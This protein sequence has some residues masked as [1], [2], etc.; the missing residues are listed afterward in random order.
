MSEKVVSTVDEY[1]AAILPFQQKVFA[2]IHRFGSLRPAILFRGEK[3]GV[4]LVA[5]IGKIVEEQNIEHPLSFER[6]RL[7]ITQSILGAT[8]KYTD[9]DLVALSQHCGIET[10]FLDW[11]SNSLVALWFA[12]NSKDGCDKRDAIVW[13]LETVERDFLISEDEASPIPDKKGAQTVIFTPDLIDS[14]MCA[15][16]SY[17]MRQVYEKMLDDRLK[18]R[19][20]DK[21]PIFKGRIHKIRI[22]NSNIK[23]MNDELR[24]YGYTKE[25]LIP[26]SIWAVVKK[27]CDDL[28]AD[29]GAKKLRRK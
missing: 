17:L 10:R 1:L 6:N 23:L 25:S 15:Q 9:W 13:I 18:I 7:R 5:K 16:E 14:R 26:D 12:I 28:I 11:T 29:Y 3:A 2:Q 27:C 20:V 24:K 8:D 19:S 22:S 4:P 21:N